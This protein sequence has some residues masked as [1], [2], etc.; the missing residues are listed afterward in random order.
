MKVSKDILDEQIGVEKAAKA[1]KLLVDV[2]IPSTKQE[3][4]ISNVILR[5][6]SI[7]EAE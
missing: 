6:I 3:P 7:L 4:Y 1:K 2:L 5:L